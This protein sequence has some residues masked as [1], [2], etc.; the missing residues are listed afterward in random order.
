MNDSELRVFSPF[1]RPSSD[2]QNLVLPELSRFV[3][4][5]NI[6]NRI[7]GLQYIEAWLRYIE[8]PYVFD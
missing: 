1:G 3:P 4:P 5:Q 2:T 7:L 8:T 6:E